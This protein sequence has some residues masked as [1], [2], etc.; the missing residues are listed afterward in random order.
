MNKPSKEAREFA[1]GMIRRVI[2][3]EGKYV[4]NANYEMAGDVLAEY[5]AHAYEIGKE[6]GGGDK[7]VRGNLASKGRKGPAVFV[8]ARDPREVAAQ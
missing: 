1:R 6:S 8:Q 2:D 4:A 7:R 3:G 5:L